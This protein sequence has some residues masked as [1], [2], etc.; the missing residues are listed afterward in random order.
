MSKFKGLIGM[1]SSLFKAP[2]IPTLPKAEIPATPAAVPQTNAGANIV[3]GTPV[4]TSR[5]SG[6]G[7][8]K[9]KIDPL[10]FLGLGGLSI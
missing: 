5:V 6:S 3:L 9:K 4:D 8:A 7:T 10:G 2:K 1:V